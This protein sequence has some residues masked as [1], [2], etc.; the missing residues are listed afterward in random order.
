M[1]QLI[2][3]KLSIKVS[4]ALALITIPAMIA[5]AY[6]ITGSEGR[7]NEQ[8]TIES[9]KVGAMTTAR[10]YGLALESGV[11]AGFFT[12]KDL[13][14]PTYEQIKGFE[15]GDNQ[16]FHTGYDAYCDRTVTVIQDKVL[17]SSPDFVYAVGGDVNGYTPTHN[18][19]FEN[20]ITGDRVKD[21]VAYRAKRKFT[22]D[23]HK[24]AHRSLEP[25][26]VQPYVRDTG[27]SIWDVSAPIFVKGQHWGAFRVGVARDSIAAHRRSLLIQL[28][29]V[30][31]FLALVTV[32][33][34]FLILRRAMRPLEG[35]V[36]AADELSTGEGFDKP[37]HIGS[38]DE[39]GQMGKS[40]N[41]LRASIA[42]AM[43]R[44]GE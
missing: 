9:A 30:F 10:T 39:I 43:K 13:M 8:M 1:L 33:C 3:R 12:I 38:I 32:G 27:D 37:I 36:V 11:D 14:E 23:V 6:V 28:G 44:L 35:L 41:R 7:L 19:R 5:A 4:L 24:A 16:R 31:G 29:V 25:V 18:T 20:V 34:I 21:L 17:E 26:L 40:V 22:T 42:S 2:R 15:W